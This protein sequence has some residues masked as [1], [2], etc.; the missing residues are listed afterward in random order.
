MDGADE[1]LDHH[2]MAAAETNQIHMTEF[3]LMNETLGM[4][5]KIP[6]MYDGKTSWFQYEELIDDWVDLTQLADDKQGPALK[7]RLTG[8]AATYKPLLDREK[9]KQADGVDYFKSVLREHFVKGAQNVFLWRFS[10]SCRHT[11]V[12]MTSSN[13]RA[14][15]RSPSR[16]SRNRGWTSWTGKSASTLRPTSTMSSNKIERP[17]WHDKQR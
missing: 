2:A 3:E 9:L 11:V 4:T 16:G 1:L 6:P 8:E 10:S 7:S 17:T 14:S 12:R 5:S 13:G 15:S